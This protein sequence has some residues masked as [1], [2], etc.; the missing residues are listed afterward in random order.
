MVSQASDWTPVWTMAV[1]TAAFSLKHFLADFVLQSG[2]IALGKDCK[3]H[4]A[5]PLL[6]HVAI[7]AGLA[8][9]IVV[10][11]APRLWWLALVD[12]V[13][14]FIVDRGKSVLG[15]CGCWGPQ[16]ARYWWVFGFDQFLHQLTNIGLSLALLVL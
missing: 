16:N 10:S 1:L 6:A 11:V 4:W 15:R 12:L 14:H 2:W 7:H 3:D 9:V 13:V 8:L 5:K